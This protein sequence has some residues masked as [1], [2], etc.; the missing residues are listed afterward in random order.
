MAGDPLLPVETARERLLDG[1]VPLG[2]ESV[3]IAAAAGRVLAEDL[4]ALRT[5]PP[6]A[7]SAMD[8]YAVRAAD[9]VTVPS[10]LQV[11]GVAP[12]GRAFA[13]TLGPGQAVR[14]FTGAPMPE[15]A[16]TVLLQEDAEV[17]GEG[18]ILSR[19]ATA[20]GRHVRAAGID[21]REGDAL[22][23]AGRVLDWRAVSLAA[24]M[25]HATVPVRRRPRVAILATGDELVLPGEPARPDQIVAS[26]GFGVAAAVAA[27]GG[28]PLDLGIAA[29][30]REAIAERIRAARAAEADVLVT[31]GGASVGDLDLV[32]STL[33]D[34]GLDLTFWKIAM[35]PGKPLMFGRLGA[36]RVLGLPGNPVSSLV[37]TILFLKPLIRALLG[38]APLFDPEEPAVAAVG[39]E[40]NDRRQDYLRATIEPGTGAGTP[41]RVKPVDRQDSSL[42]SRLAAAHCLIVRPPH[43]P[44]LAAGEACRIMRLD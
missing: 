36:M 25:G 22:L 11:I 13:G 23:T 9:I 33:A 35:R 24:A 12:A 6:F 42:V 21:F 7:A 3:P 16:D 43:A 38:T 14:I 1:V 5:Q 15:G 41:A 27:A 17:V 44:A 8:G 31:L 18:V 29:D 26:N 2:V 19:E 37:C 32:R 4:A 10:R 28:E 34:E 20:R 40:P 39:L 30:T